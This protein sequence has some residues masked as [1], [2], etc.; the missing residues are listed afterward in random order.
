M[1]AQHVEVLEKDVEPCVRNFINL[2]IFVHL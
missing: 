1:E 2:D